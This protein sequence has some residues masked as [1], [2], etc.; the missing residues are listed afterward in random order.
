MAASFSSTGVQ[1][2][3]T[4]L[5]RSKFRLYLNADGDVVVEIV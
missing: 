5:P 1:V 4:Q 2:P 3:L